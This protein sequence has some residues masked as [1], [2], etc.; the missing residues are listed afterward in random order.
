MYQEKEVKPF[1]QKFK[2]YRRLQ[3]KLTVERSKPP[4]KR[5]TTKTTLLLANINGL[6][7]EMDA[8]AL[9]LIPENGRKKV[10]A[11]VPLVKGDSSNLVN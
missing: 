3:A 2:Q 4:G 11:D 10:K 8:L 9:Q 5:D 6:L 7:K 1:V